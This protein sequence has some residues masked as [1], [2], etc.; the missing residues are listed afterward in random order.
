MSA[1]TAER[2][3][4]SASSGK[5]GAAPGWLVGP[6]FDAL[7]IANVAWPLLVLAFVGEAQG[8]TFD[9]VITL[10]PTGP[11]AVDVYF[12]IAAGAFAMTGTGTK[13]AG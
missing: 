7:F 10:E 1:I 2:R 5:V 13:A 8:Q 9:A 4:P 12:D 6:W 11:D 3:A